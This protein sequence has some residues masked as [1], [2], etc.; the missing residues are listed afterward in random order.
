MAKKKV[1]SGEEKTRN[2]FF[3]RGEKCC[4]PKN[5]FCVAR[6]QPR[7]GAT[8]F[9]PAAKNVARQKTRFALRATNLA[10]ALAAQNGHFDPHVASAQQRSI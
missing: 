10:A 8:F 2:I 4:V 9:S 7:G 1:A 5:A 3:A 6:N